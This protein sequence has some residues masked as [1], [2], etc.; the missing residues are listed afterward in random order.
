MNS[1]DNIRLL[2]FLGSLI[3]LKFD[4]YLKPHNLNAAESQKGK[5]NISCIVGDDAFKLCQ[6]LT[7]TSNKT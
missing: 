5:S 7:F 2:S 1:T 6:N 4:P 3:L